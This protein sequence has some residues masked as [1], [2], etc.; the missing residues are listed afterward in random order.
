LLQSLPVVI[1]CKFLAFFFV[2]VYR[3]I[4]DYLST[5]D[6]VVQVK[7]SILASVF[8]VVAVTFLFRFQ[9]FSKGVFVID[10]LLTTTFLLGTRGSFRMFF[11]RMKRK[12][13]TGESVLIYGAGRGGELLLREILNNS[14]MNVKPLG[15]IDDNPLKKGK[16]L[17][18]YPVLGNLADLETLIRSN[19][20]NGLLISFKEP[21]GKQFDRLKEFCHEQGIYLKLFSIHLDDVRL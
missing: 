14:S 15:F 10:W 16:K 7:A 1:I 2:G 19:K 3:T 13:K 9:D 17:Q 8:A 4:W 21:N 6:V 20:I 12:T 18:G 5:E 11:D